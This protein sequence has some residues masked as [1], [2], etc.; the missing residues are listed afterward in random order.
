MLLALFDVSIVRAQTRKE[1][2]R[3]R[4]GIVAARDNSRASWRAAQELS[5]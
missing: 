4:E 5:L 2:R 3:L 1:Q